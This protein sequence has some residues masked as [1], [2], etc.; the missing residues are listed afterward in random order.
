MDTYSKKFQPVIAPP[1]NPSREAFDRYLAR[2]VE[3]ARNN[4]LIAGRHG[5]TLHSPYVVETS[6]RK[7]TFPMG[8]TAYVDVERRVPGEVK[9]VIANITVRTKLDGRWVGQA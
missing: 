6:R 3:M 1:W 9:Q 5:Q 8:S 4:L 2:E 7:G